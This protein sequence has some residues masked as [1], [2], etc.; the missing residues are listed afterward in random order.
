MHWG[1]G[2]G[3][4]MEGP[5][6][7]RNLL[8]CFARS[9]PSPAAASAIWYPLCGCVWCFTHVSS[10]VI[11]TQGS[12]VGQGK[13][14]A[15]PSPCS[16][17]IS[18]VCGAPVP[19]CRLGQQTRKDALV[20]CCIWGVWKGC[21]P[22]LLSDHRFS[23]IFYMAPTD[24]VPTT[25]HSGCCKETDALEWSSVHKAFGGAR[26]FIGMFYWN[27]KEKHTCRF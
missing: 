8:L 23:H 6:P 2:L 24:W 21:S 12:D 4:P 14:W 19:C 7:Q 5:V 10:L 20:P 9:H 25:S 16:T 11:H 1:A 27:V 18:R 22:W 13:L 3:T 17:C 15:S 26:H